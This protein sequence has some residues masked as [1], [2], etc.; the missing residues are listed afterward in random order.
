MGINWHRIRNFYY[1]VS[2]VSF[3]VCSLFCL[4]GKIVVWKNPLIFI[5]MLSTATILRNWIDRIVARVLKGYLL[6]LLILVRPFSRSRAT[7]SVSDRGS[8][9]RLSVRQRNQLST[10]M[11]P[12]EN[13][14]AYGLFLK[15]FIL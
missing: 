8:V 10:S 5:M 1:I 13:D 6:F 4:D 15:T 9:Q 2:K 7:P 11:G 12:T 3:I 14:I